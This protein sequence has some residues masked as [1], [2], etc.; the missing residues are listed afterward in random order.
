MKN[1]ITQQVVSFRFV[2]QIIFF[3]CAFSLFASMHAATYYVAPNGNDSSPGTE[4]QPWLTIQKAANTLIAGDIVYIKAGTYNERVIPQN[5][6]TAGNYI[7][8][9]VY[10]GDQVTIDGNGISLP[11]EWGGL[12]D[13]SDKGYIRVSGLRVINAKPYDNS[14][15][16]LVDRC[17]NIIIENN[18]TYN[19][20]SSGIGVWNSEN[21]IIDGNEVE[22]ACNDG[23]QECITVAVTN[24]FEI[25]NNNVHHG[26]PGSNGGEGID[27][28]DGSSNGKVFNNYVH[29]ITNKLG[30]YCEAWDKYTHDIDI[31]NNI[32]HDCGSEGITIS[33]EQGGLLENIKVYNNIVYNNKFSGI[34]VAPNGDVPDSPMKNISI[35]NN[36]VFNN[37]WNTGDA[38]WGGGIEIDSPNLS[39]LVIRNNIVSDNLLFQIIIWIYKDNLSIDHNLI[40]GFRDDLAEETRGDNYV[41]GDPL[42]VNSSGADFHLQENSPAIDN[43]STIQAPDTDFEGNS[44]PFGAGIDMGAFE[45][46]SAT[47]VS[48][49]QD[50]SIRTFSLEQNY[51]NPFNPST[52]I[53]FTLKERV[54]TEIK[55]FDILGSEVASLINENLNA[56]FYEVVF[57][58]NQLTSGVYI[59]RIIA[60]N[61]AASRKMNLVK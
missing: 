57:N 18:Y 2:S 29:D 50:N 35:I 25:K 19:T 60:G 48:D 14:V 3:I 13:I 52:T 38:P 8:Y 5:S 28:K 41:E 49:W 26:G 45:Y 20:A 30:I 42:F 11:A 53:K 44:R 40:D 55:V 58:T 39:G 15:G 24:G 59:Y 22:L 34:I 10:P 6:G 21:V 56:G 27:A 36:T 17:N 46:G 12:F 33:S 1:Q 4:N 16:I 37:G 51:P 47:A 61:F 31:Y 7:L 23:E 54:F 32:V 43:G 9:A